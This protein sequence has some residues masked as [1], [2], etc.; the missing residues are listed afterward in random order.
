MRLGAP[1][2]VRAVVVDTSHFTGNFPSEASVEGAGRRRAPVG[3]RAC[4]RPTGRPLVRALAAAGRHRERLRR[5]VG[6]RWTHVRLTHPPGRRRRPAAGARRGR[7]RPATGRGARHRRPRRARARRP[8]HRLQQPVLRVAG[9][10]DRPRAGPVDGGGLG[11]RAAPRRRQRLGRGAAGRARHR[12]GSSSWTRPGSSATRPAAAALSAYDGDGDRADPTRGPRCSNAPRC[13]P[14]P[15]TASC[16]R[17]VGAGHPRAPRRLPRR[18]DGPAAAVG[19]ARPTTGWPP[20]GTGGTRP[21]D[22]A[23]RRPA[24]AGRPARPCRRGARRRLAGRAGRP[25]AGAHA[26]PAGRPGRRRRRDPAPA[27]TRWTRWPA[28]D[29]GSMARITGLDAAVVGE[30]WPRVLAK[31]A[32][33]AGRGPAARPRGRLRRRDPTTRRTGTRRS[34]GEVAR[35]RWAARARRS[36]AASGS[37]RWRR[38]PGGAACARSTWCSARFGGAAAGRLRRD[39][40][41]GHLGRPGARRWCCSASGSRSAHGFPARRRCASRCRSRRRRPC[42]V[43]TARRR[44]PAP[45]TRPAGGAPVCTTAP[46]TTAPRS[47][48]PPRTSRWST[49]SPTTRR[50]SMQVAAAQTGVRVS[51]GS[52]NVLPL[53]DRGA[54][55]GGLGAARATGAAVAGARH[56]PGLG[57][58]PRAAADPLPR[59]VRVLPAGAAPPRSRGC[60]ATSTAGRA[61]CSTSRRR[62]S[63]WPASC[64]AASTAARWTPTRSRPPAA[65]TAPTL[66]RLARRDGC[67]AV[68]RRAA[69]GR[70][71]ARRC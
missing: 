28:Q 49:R 5:L 20:C 27:P 7:R 39:P 44:S 32:P 15:G 12:C 66:R 58:A 33:R 4:A 43:P 25:A 53:G 56:L 34:A 50:P 11:D 6:R 31:L 47:V 17:A 55:R 10:A 57:P 38:R 54:R 62:R 65:R 14:T 63:R 16:C 67:A 70:A 3:R 36:S 22:P 30:V 23:R 26:V 42:S 8:G 60:A 69:G 21:D 2:V 18:R 52:T 45:C 64:C 59:D 71:P 48:S 24:R 51:D 29:A 68:A 46:T 37:S 19:P 40:A 9:P 13:S 35:R 41:E 1:G 61:A